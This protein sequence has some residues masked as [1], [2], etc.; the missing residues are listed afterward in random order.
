M[1]PE[2]SYC[3][4][5][6]FLVR[7]RDHL[8]PYFSAELVAQSLVVTYHPGSSELLSAARRPQL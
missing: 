1:N 6:E 5:I 7:V 8:R 3:G 4:D 2:R